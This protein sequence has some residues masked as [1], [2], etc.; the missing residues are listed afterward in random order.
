MA[1]RH[2]KDEQTHPSSHTTYANLHTP[3]KDERLSRL[4]EENRKAKVQIKRLIQK[5]ESAT[6]QDGVCLNDELHNDFKLIA[7]MNTKDI[8]STYPEDSF[9]RL[10]WD[11]QVK[12]SSYKNSK[13]MKWHPLFIKWCLY[14]RHL[15]SKSYEHL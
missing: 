15:S 6:I 7:S 11:Q 12:A 10:F 1:S 8:H 13:S 14:L 3:E 5:I 4:H 9:E 2:Q